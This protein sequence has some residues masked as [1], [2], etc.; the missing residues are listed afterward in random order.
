MDVKLGGG[1]GR[2]R[3]EVRSTAVGKIGGGRDIDV[4]S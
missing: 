3:D 4:S 2:G 1:G